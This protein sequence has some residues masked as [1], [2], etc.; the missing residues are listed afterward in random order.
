VDFG[1]FKEIFQNIEFFEKF[2]HSFQLDSIHDETE[3]NTSDAS[4]DFER[5]L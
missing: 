1:Y 5:T 2:L 3:V 4:D